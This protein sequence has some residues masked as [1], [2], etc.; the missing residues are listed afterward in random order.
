M[1][2]R[3][4]VL[5][6]LTYC[7]T[8]TARSNTTVSTL[9]FLT[10]IALLSLAACYTAEGNRAWADR[11]VYGILDNATEKVLGETREFVVE[12]PIDTLRKR[13]MTDSAPVKLTLAQALDVAAALTTA[14][15]NLPSVE[16]WRRFRAAAFGRAPWCYRRASSRDEARRRPTTRREATRQV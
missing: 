15:N 11:A 12:R 14:G 9:R 8:G 5:T 2:H 16:Q 1:T 13:L 6:W 10:L 7:L 4:G 3:T